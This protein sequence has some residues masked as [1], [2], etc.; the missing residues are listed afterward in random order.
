MRFK[1]SF[2]VPTHVRLNLVKESKIGWIQCGIVKAFER[3]GKSLYLENNFPISFTGRHGFDVSKDNDVEILADL[4][5]IPHDKYKEFRDRLST[6]SRDF[7][8]LSAMRE[9]MG[10]YFIYDNYETD[11]TIDSI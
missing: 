6:L 9:L 4:V 8:Q 3:F 5:V 1:F 11:T 7:E 10:K 2:I